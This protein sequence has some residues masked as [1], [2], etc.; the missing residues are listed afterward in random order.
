MGVAR[1]VW[2]KVSSVQVKAHLTPKVPS[3]EGD[4]LQSSLGF[5]YF[6]IVSLVTHNN[7]H[8]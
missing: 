8:C 6:Y 1:E 2:S 3:H 4:A 5:E 7:A